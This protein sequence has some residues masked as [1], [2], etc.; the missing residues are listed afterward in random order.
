MDFDYDYTEVGSIGQYQELKLATCFGGE[1]LYGI[2]SVA[3]DPQEDLLWTATYGVC[4]Q[5][6][7]LVECVGGYSLFVVMSTSL[8][9]SL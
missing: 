9:F 4:V 7:G 8:L 2:S 5:V 6:Q 1:N 3:F